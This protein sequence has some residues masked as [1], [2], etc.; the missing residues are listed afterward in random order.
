MDNQTVRAVSCSSFILHSA[1]NNTRSKTDDIDVIFRR[2]VINLV[3]TVIFFNDIDITSCSS[4]QVIISASTKNSII[5]GTT[6]NHILS[7]ASM[8]IITSCCT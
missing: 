7:I 3:N 6:S 5:P 2:E 8:Q 4:N 1:I